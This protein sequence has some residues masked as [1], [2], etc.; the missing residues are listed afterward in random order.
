MQLSVVIPAYNEEECIES[1]IHEV[2]NV[3][4]SSHVEFE[5][6]VVDDGSTDG[7]ASILKELRHN[8]PELRALRITP[9][10]GQTAAF[11]A[12][13][14][15]ARGKFTVFMD[16]DGQNDP[17]DILSIVE[18]LQKADVCCG[19]RKNRRDKLGRR[20]ASGVA[21]AV[22][23]IFLRESVKD[24]GCSLKAF[25]TEL[26]KELPWELSGMHRFLPALFAMRGAR[27]VEIPVNHRPRTTGKSKY[28]N[29]GRLKTTWLDLFAI[30]W[31]KSR[32]RRYS[33][34]EIK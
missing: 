27:I 33:V 32:M 17:S 11:G 1:T 4:R 6:I 2:V 31:M 29:L 19:W 15:Y 7:T 26:A 30:K 25:R 8:L 14:K 18:Q 21:N 34:E 10:S 12:G 24:T 5:V 3:L 23:N 13:V 16:A 9:H 22:R 20:L 28:T